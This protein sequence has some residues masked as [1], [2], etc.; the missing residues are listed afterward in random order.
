MRVAAP[1]P[2]SQDLALFSLLW[3]FS[4]KLACRHST[5]HAGRHVYIAVDENLR[6][7]LSLHGYHNMRTLT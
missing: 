2:V 1:C 7:Y 3:S 6:T 5:W 4:E